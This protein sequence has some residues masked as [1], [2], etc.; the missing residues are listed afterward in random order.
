[1]SVLSSSISLPVLRA[2]A[3]GQTY[4]LQF[5]PLPKKKKKIKTKTKPTK[6]TRQAKAE[7]DES[8]NEE[9]EEEEEE[10]AVPKRKKQNTKKRSQKKKRSQRKR[11]HR[12]PEDE[13]DDELD[14]P[15]IVVKKRNPKSSRP[16]K[17]DV[18]AAA[19]SLSLVARLDACRATLDSIKQQ[20]KDEL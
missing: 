14:A 17:G 2:P 18:S 5:E 12:W 10:E 19:S 16:A 4:H 9:K 15:P 3:Y 13:D 6:H 8:E 11:K 1:M 20:W 7:E